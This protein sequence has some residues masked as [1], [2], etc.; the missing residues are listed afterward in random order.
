[1]GSLWKKLLMKFNIFGKFLHFETEKIEVKNK[2]DPI[3]KF[4]ECILLPIF[5]LCLFCGWLIKANWPLYIGF[6][7]LISGIIYF[8][9]QYEFMKRRDPNGLRSEKHIIERKKMAI[10]EEVSK[11]I[12]PENAESFLSSLPLGQSFP[13]VGIADDKEEHE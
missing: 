6:G 10:I 7:I 13:E 11:R 8:F 9:Y 2:L 1:M 12:R 4:E 5:I 3:I